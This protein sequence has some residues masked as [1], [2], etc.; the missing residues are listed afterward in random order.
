VERNGVLARLGFEPVTL[1]TRTVSAD[2]NRRFKRGFRRR[3]AF[4]IFISAAERFPP[5]RG[6]RKREV[7]DKKAFLCRSR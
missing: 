4:F 3:F 5:R 6:S 1:G 2:F 7:A